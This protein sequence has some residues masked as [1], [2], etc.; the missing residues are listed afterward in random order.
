M[1]DPDDHGLNDQE[2]F[3][4]FGQRPYFYDFRVRPY[5]ADDGPPAV[6]DEPSITIVRSDFEKL[7]GWPAAKLTFQKRPCRAASAAEG[8]VLGYLAFSGAISWEGTPKRRKER[9]Q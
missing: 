3:R 1:T 6:V 4:L 7:V 5:R 8:D 2:W 9:P